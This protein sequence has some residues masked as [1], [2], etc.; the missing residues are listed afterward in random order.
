LDDSQSVSNTEFNEQQAFAKNI[1]NRFS[2]FGPNDIQISVALFGIARNI[3]YLNEYS[4]Q[5]NIGIAINAISRQ[6]G[7]NGLGAGL[8]VSG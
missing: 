8:K 2:L 3:F 5:M 1:V 6:L 4:T 7:S